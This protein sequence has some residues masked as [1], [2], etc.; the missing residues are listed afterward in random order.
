M[1]EGVGARLRQARTERGLDLPEI[2]AATKIQGRLLAAMEEEDWDRLSGE[3]YVRAFLRE[4]AEFLGLDSGELLDLYEP[5]PAR[6]EPPPRQIT[7]PPQLRSRR[8]RGPSW[9]RVSSALGA[10]AV[11]VV[12]S[13]GGGEMRAPSPEAKPPASA[14]APAGEGRTGEAEAQPAP[15]HGTALTLLAT[16]E[17]WVCLL[18]RKGEPLVDGQILAA[19]IEVGPFRSGAYALSLGNGAVEVTLDGSPAPIPPSSDPVGYAIDAS[20]A[21]RE[22][23]P[24]ERPTCT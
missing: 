4:Y 9:L 15:S 5:E 14:P 22:L 19:G 17:V 18:D 24:D 13:L 8:G 6:A 20:G 7:S 12:S 1:V 16:A 2:E 21:L 10:V 3:Y 23:S 11:I